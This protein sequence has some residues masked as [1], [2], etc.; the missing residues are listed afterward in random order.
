MTQKEVI[1]QYFM[2]HPNC[3]IK[4]AEVVDWATKKYK[5]ST[6]SVLR[7]PDRAI[8]TLYEEG[9]LIR[10]AKGV[11]KYDPSAVGQSD[12]LTFPAEIIEAAKERDGYRCVVCGNGEAEGEIIT[13]DH[14]K[15]RSKGGQAT[16]DNAQTLCEKCHNLKHTYGQTHFGKKIFLRLKPKAEE[17]NDTNMINFINAVLAVYEQYGIDDTE[18]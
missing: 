7:D 16:L 17:A 8:R 4:T 6:K 15:P 11:Y 13:V 10:I 5:R 9:F 14:I 12:D 3:E 2:D 18:E 1:M